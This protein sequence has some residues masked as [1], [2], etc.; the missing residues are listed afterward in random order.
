MIKMVFLK[1]KIQNKTPTPPD[2]GCGTLSVCSLKEYIN[3]W[4]INLRIL[5][6]DAPHVLTVVVSNMSDDAAQSNVD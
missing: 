3:A 1:G 2:L 5:W 6:D 4:S